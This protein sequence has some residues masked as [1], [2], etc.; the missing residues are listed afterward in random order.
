MIRRIAILCWILG[1]GIGLVACQGTMPPPC[2]L[3]RDCTMRPVN[4]R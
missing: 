1:F 3:D 2:F 4:G